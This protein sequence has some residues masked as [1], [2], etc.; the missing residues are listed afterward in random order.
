MI[1]EALEYLIGLGNANIHYENGQTLSDKRMHLLKEP[2]ASAIEVNSLSGLVDYLVSEFDYSE[3]QKLM[4]HVVSPTQVIV[5]DP[6][7]DDKER[8]EY[9][10]A[11]AMVPT[12]RFDN[13]YDSE[14]FIIKL[15]S[16]FVQNE[17]RDIALKVVG[18]IK[19][20]DV[21]STGDDGVSQ[22]VTAKTGVATVGNVKV[23]NPIVLKPYR[24]FVEVEQPE[25]E[26]IFRMQSGPRCSLFEADGGAWKLNAMQNIK[27]YLTAALEEEMQSG[28]IFIIA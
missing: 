25:S 10:S 11:K 7:N 14:N 9:L 2:T 6:L 13:W 15:Q 4:V 24:T 22:V 17:D 21:R 28:K 23:P 12:F 5:F 18:N 1:R 3:G 26:F 19:E 20:E 27:D 16:C 8:N